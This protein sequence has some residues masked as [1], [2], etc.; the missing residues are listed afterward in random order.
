M[1]A[2]GQPTT[3]INFYSQDSKEN[4]IECVQTE[5]IKTKVKFDVDRAFRDQPR[6]AFS[7]TDVL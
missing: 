3:I 5:L 7:G 6:S 2:A 4:G 1:S